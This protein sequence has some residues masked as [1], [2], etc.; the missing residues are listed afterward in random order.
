M[1]GFQTKQGQ[2]LDLSTTPD[3]EP[4]DTFG[5]KMR[6]LL[7]GPA[8]NLPR[9]QMPREPINSAHFISTYSP[10]GVSKV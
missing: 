3:F 7:G 1:S 5:D 9:F 10:G 4:Q 8:Q 2:G 6:K